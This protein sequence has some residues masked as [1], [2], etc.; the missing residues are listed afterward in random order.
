M[1][2]NTA[3]FSSLITNAEPTDIIKFI[4]S[5]ITVY[6]KVVDT[7]EH[8]NKVNFELNSYFQLI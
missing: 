8:V 3:D 2:I 5:T 6:D 7:Y 4:N 1:F